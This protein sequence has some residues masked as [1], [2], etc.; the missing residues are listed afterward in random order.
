[1]E[2]RLLPEGYGDGWMSNAAQDL[3]R[4]A[5]YF[6][7]FDASEVTQRILATSDPRRTTNITTVQNVL[8]EI[9]WE[10]EEARV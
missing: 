1:M 5:V 4:V 9:D 3:V 6:A 8:Q 10:I 2:E 7:G